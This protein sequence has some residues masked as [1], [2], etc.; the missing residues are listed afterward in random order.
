MALDATVGGA[1]SNSYVTLSEAN[2]YFADRAHVDAWE[3]EDNQPQALITASQVIDWYVTWKGVRVSGVQSMDWPRSGVYDKVGVLYPEDV[4]PPDVKIA[5]YEMAL[6]SLEGDRTQDGD[7]AGL[8]E[9]RAASLM[10][11]TD[12]GLYNTKPDT[13]PDHIWKILS[14]LTTKSGIGVV[15]LVRA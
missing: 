6:A 13:I 5:V 15:R 2:S 1:T 7:L 3:S 10:I 14:G 4:I 8:S 9:V 11:K 12:D